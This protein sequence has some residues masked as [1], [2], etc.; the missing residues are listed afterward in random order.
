[1]CVVL[2]I[3]VPVL[4]QYEGCTPNTSCL[5]CVVRVNAGRRLVP[6]WSVMIAAEGMIVESETD[7]TPMHAGSTPLELLLAD[8]AGDCKAPCTNVCPAHMDI[9]SMI[10]HIEA[11]D[12]RCMVVVKQHIALPAVLGRICPELCEKGCRRAGHTAVSICRLKRYVADV[13]LQSGNP[14]CRPAAI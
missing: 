14:G 9:P 13:D 12:A 6:S 4:C 1:M 2:G 5:C 7:G 11:G 10:G 8:H 3:D